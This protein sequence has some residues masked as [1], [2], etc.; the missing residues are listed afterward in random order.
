MLI[1]NIKE[2]WCQQ[3]TRTVHNKTSNKILCW[4]INSHPGLGGENSCKPGALVALYSEN[5]DPWVQG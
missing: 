5:Y 3:V 1:I 4:I 2:I